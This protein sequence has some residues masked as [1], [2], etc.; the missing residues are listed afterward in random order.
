MMMMM[1]LIVGCLTACR[2]IETASI[3]KIHFFR[4]VLIFDGVLR[5]SAEEVMK[6]CEAMDQV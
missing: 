5:A 1:I 6:E 2:S 3:Y 4:S